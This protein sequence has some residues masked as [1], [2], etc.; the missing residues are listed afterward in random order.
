MGDVVAV[1]IVVETDE[2][3]ELRLRPRRDFTARGE[4]ELRAG[5][6]MRIMDCMSV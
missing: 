1:L 3:L 5:R 6:C 4:S 2:S